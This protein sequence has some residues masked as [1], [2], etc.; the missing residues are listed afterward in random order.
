M[1][2][3]RIGEIV[4]NGVAR[5][6]YHGVLTADDGPYVATWTWKGK[7]VEKPLT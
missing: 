7:E 5:A 6:E 2:L 3:G 4:F 1:D